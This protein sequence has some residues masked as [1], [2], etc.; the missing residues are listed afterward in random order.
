MSVYGNLVFCKAVFPVEKAL[1]HKA[2]A[3]TFDGHKLLTHCLVISIRTCLFVARLS[4]AD[5]DKNC[6]AVSSM[7]MALIFDITRRN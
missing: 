1:A 2:N 4:I 3:L 6:P 5:L 7:S